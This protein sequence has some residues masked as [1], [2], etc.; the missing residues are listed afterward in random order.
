MK[1]N[2]FT[3]WLGIIIAT[4]LA[5]DVVLILMNYGYVPDDMAMNVVE[6]FIITKLCALA[7]VAILVDRAW[8]LLSGLWRKRRIAA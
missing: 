8:E 6:V 2:E 7:A 5:Y 1:L 4:R 3:K